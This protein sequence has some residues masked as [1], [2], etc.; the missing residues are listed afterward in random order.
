[1]PRA[2]NFDVWAANQVPLYRLGTNSLAYELTVI[3]RS[4]TRLREE[5]IIPYYSFVRNLGNAVKSSAHAR[6]VTIVATP[7]AP[8]DWSEDTSLDHKALAAHIRPHLAEPA[9]ALLDWTLGL[10]ARVPEPHWTSVVGVYSVLLDLFLGMTPAMG[11][12]MG[13]SEWAPFMALM[14]SDE[15]K[16]LAEVLREEVLRIRAQPGSG[17]NEE[18]AKTLVMEHA[19]LMVGMMTVGT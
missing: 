5:G 16:G 10:R 8:A 6:G 17:W 7:D 14:T 4:E 2:L 13:G 11:G 3:P 1:M 15:P 12:V 9:Q 18:E 19:G